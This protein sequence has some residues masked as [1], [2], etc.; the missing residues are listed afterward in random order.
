MDGKITGNICYCFTFSI[1]DEKA[2]LGPDKK[3]ELKKSILSNYPNA[4]FDDDPERDKWPLLKDIKTGQE[5]LHGQGLPFPCFRV[6][7]P[8]YSLTMDGF[9]IFD[10]GVFMSVFPEYDTANVYVCISVK[11]GSTDDLVYMRHVQGNGR[12]LKNSDGRELSVSEIF[13]EVSRSIQRPVGEVESTY[14]LEIKKFGGYEDVQTIIE[15]EMR[16]IYGIMCGDEGWRNVPADLASERMSHQWGS[17]DFTRLVTFGTS[18]VFFNLNG[19]S[20]AGSYLD[21]RRRFD[22]IYYDGVENPYFLMDSNIAGINHGIIFSLEMVLVIKT[23]CSRVINR[24]ARFY[25]RSG[26]LI[27]MEMRKIKTYRGELI[28][29]LNKVEN[30]QISEMGELERV[31]L[32]SYN[33]EPVIEKIKYLLEILESELELLYQNSTNRLINLLT[34]AGVVLAAIQVMQGVFG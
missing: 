28:V 14:L 31:L 12:K 13:D 29:I 24:Q 20:L 26:G 4:V 16:P 2:G 30:L 32:R 17:R 25:A 33:I 23:I 9:D 3:T 11:E 6:L 7:L 21:N 18:T 27:N 1:Y 15:K 8:D 34:I 22:E 5:F 19:C 10:S